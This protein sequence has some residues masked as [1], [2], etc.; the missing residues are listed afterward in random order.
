MVS[1]IYYLP[2]SSKP[3]SNHNNVIMAPGTLFNTSISS[4]SLLVFFIVAVYLHF[5]FMGWHKQ[6]PYLMF[7]NV[8]LQLECG[9]QSAIIHVSYL[10]DFLEHV[11]QFA[12]IQ[13]CTK[14]QKWNQS[15]RVFILM[16]LV[17]FFVCP[18]LPR[19]ILQTALGKT[20][21]QEKLSSL[22]DVWWSSFRG[23]FKK[24]YSA[25]FWGAHVSSI[26]PQ[27]VVWMP[28]EL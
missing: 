26:N 23:P 19:M 6:C 8:A 2:H 13:M 28:S 9:V 24:W 16:R 22:R 20:Y 10:I 18:E 3:Y 17:K 5:F 21:L 27:E 14:G 4:H 12:R 15:T 11:T 1:C 25:P 7:H